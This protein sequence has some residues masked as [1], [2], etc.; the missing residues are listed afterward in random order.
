MR[1]ENIV[2]ELEPEEPWNS[3]VTCGPLKKEDKGQVG[4]G[5]ARSHTLRFTV[6]E[7]PPTLFA[8]VGT[9]PEPPL[10]ADILPD[11]TVGEMLLM[12]IFARL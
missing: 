7:S 9:V 8:G 4:N 10:T 3:S 5:T 1:L 2:P 12:I 11:D 6:V